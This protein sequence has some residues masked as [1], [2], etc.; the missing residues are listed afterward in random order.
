VSAGVARRASAATAHLE[1]VVR[2]CLLH[3]CE[4]ARVGRAAPGPAGLKRGR[5]VRRPRIARTSWPNGPL[6]RRRRPPFPVA[7]V[8]PPP[9]RW[10]Q[11]RDR[12]ANDD[13]EGL[14]PPPRSIQTGRT[15]RSATSS[16]DPS[17]PTVPKVSQ[18]V[19]DPGP[20]GV[21]G[22]A[23]IARTASVRTIGSGSN[24]AP[25]RRGHPESPGVGRIPRWPA[26]PR[27]AL[28]GPDRAGRADATRPSSPAHQRHVRPR[29]APTGARQSRRT[30]RTSPGASPRTIQPREAA[31]SAPAASRRT[32]PV[33]EGRCPARAAQGRASRTRLESPQP[34][35]RSGSPRSATALLRRK[36]ASLRERSPAR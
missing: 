16:F 19:G 13:A 3:G 31:A 4:A 1:I 22:S 12:T 27:V 8:P 28:L 25:P 29:G 6:R 18:D 21:A 11:P 34:E 36:A 9:P 20:S 2:Y 17:S 23:A 24:P 14:T 26:P 5:L 10:P 32:H 33:G 35:G 30:P 15:R 7:A